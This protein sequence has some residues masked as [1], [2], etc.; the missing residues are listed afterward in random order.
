M[1]N[2]TTV[3][4]VGAGSGALAGAQIGGLPGALVGGLAG[5]LFGAF[6]GR[7]RAP[8]IDITAEL[9]RIRSLFEKERTEIEAASTRLFGRQT[10]ALRG[11][12]ALRGTFRSPVAEAELGRLAEG[13]QAQLQQA[14]GGSFGRQAQAEAGVLSSL[15]GIRAGQE[16][17]Q[18]AEDQQRQA[19]LFGIGGAALA[20]LLRP[21][22]APTQ[23]RPQRQTRL[24]FSPTQTAGLF[25]QPSFSGLQPSATTTNQNFNLLSSLG[26]RV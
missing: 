3:G 17:Q 7:R 2:G 25:A 10:G 21:Q 16:A 26:F 1:A 22:S 24:D 5:G 19:S 13:Q 15:L 14:L 6:G 20:G 18:R 11:R 8:T 4:F 12:Q 9:N 23:R